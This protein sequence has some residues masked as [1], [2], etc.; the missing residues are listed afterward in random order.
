[1]AKLVVKKN[2]RSEILEYLIACIIRF[3]S[4]TEEQAEQCAILVKEIGYCVIMERETYVLKKV[5]EDFKQVGIV[6][7]IIE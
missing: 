1:M 5:Q 6:T 3:C 2:E 4:Y 7:N